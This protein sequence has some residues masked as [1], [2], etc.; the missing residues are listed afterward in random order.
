MGKVMPGQLRRW[1]QHMTGRSTRFLVLEEEV[2]KFGQGTGDHWNNVKI[3]EGD[4]VKNASVFQ[5]LQK[6]EIISETSQ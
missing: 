4:A 1:K 2:N 3:L 5:I 6:S